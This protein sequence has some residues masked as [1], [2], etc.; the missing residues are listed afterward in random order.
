M[1]DRRPE[2]GGAATRR[3]SAGPGGPSTESR[4]PKILNLQRTVGNSAVSGL[5]AARGLT[6]QRQ[7]DDWDED[8]DWQHG[9][10]TRPVEGPNVAPAEPPMWDPWKGHPY[11]ERGTPPVPDED[12]ESSTREKI[13]RALEKAGVPAWAVAGVIVLIIAALADPEPFTKIA[14]LIGTAAADCLPG[15]NRPRKRRSA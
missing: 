5:L 2:Q 3:Y 7:T 8:P 10:P 14:L 9:A 4:I 1:Y 12:E 15:C 11:R 6:V 13:A